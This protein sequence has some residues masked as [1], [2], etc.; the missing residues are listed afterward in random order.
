MLDENSTLQVKQ[1]T[2]KEIGDVNDLLEDR[3]LVVSDDY[4]DWA[5]AEEEKSILRT[6]AEPLRGEQGGL[7]QAFL[8]SRRRERAQILKTQRLKQ[9]I[10]RLEGRLRDQDRMV[11][12]LKEDKRSLRR[13]IRGLE[14]MR[15]SRP[16]R[17]AETLRRVKARMLSLGKSP[18]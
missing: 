2:S 18:S 7:A 16:W 8:E 4:V 3:F 9:E 17:L 5:N 6:L 1:E 14:P 12:R 15:D 13:R 10:L 11:Q